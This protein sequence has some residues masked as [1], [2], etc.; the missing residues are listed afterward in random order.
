[1]FSQPSEENIDVNDK[2][3]E[4]VTDLNLNNSISQN[5]ENSIW[6]YVNSEI[7]LSQESMSQALKKVRDVVD[8][9]PPSQENEQTKCHSAQSIAITEL[10]VNYPDAL[11]GVLN[12]MLQVL[13]EEFVNLHFQWKLCLLHE[14]EWWVNAARNEKTTIDRKQSLVLCRMNHLEIVLIGKRS[15]DFHMKVSL[16]DLR[17][18]LTSLSFSALCGTN[19][20]E[21]FFNF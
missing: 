17:G 3:L 15:I 2:G 11:K 20:A 7:P 13:I 1:M 5:Q 12:N 10:A 21:F 19:M 14:D 16:L 18:N 6:N 9:T 8:S 4:S